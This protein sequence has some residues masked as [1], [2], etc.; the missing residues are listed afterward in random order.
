MSSARTPRLANPYSLGVGADQVC[1]DVPGSDLRSAALSAG[2]RRTLAVGLLGAGASV[3]LGVLGQGAAFAE[4]DETTAV[5]S[6]D[7]GGS[8]DQGSWDGGSDWSSI[9]VPTVE[10]PDVSNFESSPVSEVG[11]GLLGD[12]P[13]TSGAVA[14]ES[15]DPSLVAGPV[16]GVDVES[17]SLVVAP[18]PVPAAAPEGSPV[19][20]FWASG[21][22]AARVVVGAG[23]A[24]GCCR[25]R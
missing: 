8:S 11:S 23:A 19:R 10:L 7:G 5:E 1:G 6:F 15:S 4:D 17:S 21:C 24:V 16:S 14:A 2:V 25:R 9:E 22:G 3:G 12:G 20:R 13:D 18:V